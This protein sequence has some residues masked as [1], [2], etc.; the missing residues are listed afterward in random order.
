MSLPWNYHVGQRFVL[1]V[2]VVD[3]SQWN[4][5]QEGGQVLGIQHEVFR[6]HQLALKTSNI[7]GLLLKKDYFDFRDL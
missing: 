2:P 1:G 4:D 7:Q 3:E 5:D 6:F